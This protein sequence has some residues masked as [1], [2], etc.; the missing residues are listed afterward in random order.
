MHAV[1]CENA[2]MMKVM[3]MKYVSVKYAT[4]NT[5]TTTFIFQ[6]SC[7]QKLFLQILKRLLQ[8][9]DWHGRVHE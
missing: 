9:I 5:I 2:D 3:M 6:L 4:H 7:V 1:K 8:S